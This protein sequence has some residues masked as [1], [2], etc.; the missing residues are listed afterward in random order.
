[1]ENDKLPAGQDIH[2]NWTGMFTSRANQSFFSDAFQ[3]E[4]DKS[5][6]VPITLERRNESAHEFHGSPCSA[7]GDRVSF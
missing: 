1:M 4:V 5:P 2:V 6:V 7:R 3:V